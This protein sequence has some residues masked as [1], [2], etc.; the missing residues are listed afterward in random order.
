MMTLWRLIVNALEAHIV[1]LSTC[2]LLLARIVFADP[3][4]TTTTTVRSTNTGLTS[5]VTIYGD[6]GKTHESLGRARA[7]QGIDKSPKMSPSNAK[8]WG[9][10]HGDYSTSS[11]ESSSINS[12]N[13]FRKMYQAVD[14]HWDPKLARYAQR[15]AEKCIW[16][17][18]VR[19]IAFN[20][21]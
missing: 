19:F 1:L 5:T 18:S 14:L 13:V 15:H 6:H 21:A 3:T 4:T 12:T 8:S 11:L 16:E 10:G 7:T 2:I 17:H 9:E 20:V